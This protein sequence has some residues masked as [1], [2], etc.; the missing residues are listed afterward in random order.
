MQDLIQIYLPLTALLVILVN[1]IFFQ[2]SFLNWLPLVLVLAALG[3]VY[4]N[5]VTLDDGEVPSIVAN[6]PILI[7]TIGT[8]IALSYRQYLKDRGSR[9]Q[10]IALTILFGIAAGITFAFSGNYHSG[11][12]IFNGP[13]LLLSVFLNVMFVAVVFIKLPFLNKIFQLKP[14]DSRSI[15]YKGVIYMIIALSIYLGVFV[16]GWYGVTLFASIFLPT[17]IVLS[18]DENEDLLQMAV[19]S[20]SSIL[21][22]GYVMMNGFGLEFMVSKSE[23]LWGAFIGGFLLVLG[24]LSTL[25]AQSNKAMVILFTGIV[26]G[27]VYGLGYLYEIKENLGGLITYVG[28]LLGIAFFIF[29]FKHKGYNFSIQNGILALSAVLLFTPGFEVTD[30]DAHKGSNAD[31]IEKNQKKL[32]VTNE[33]GEKV[34]SEMIDITQAVGE[35][36]VFLDNS[37][38]KFK[39]VSHGNTTSG[40]F[41]KFTGKVKIAEKLEDCSVEM[42]F[43]AESFSTYNKTRDKEL[44]GGADWM[45]VAKFPEVS[46]EAKGFRVEGNTYVTEGELKMKGISKKIPVKFVFDGKGENNGKEFI[47]VSGSLGLDMTEFGIPESSEV[48]KGVEIEFTIEANKME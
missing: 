13:K 41:K 37:K 2:K 45:D 6:A 28:L 26:L 9:M 25:I 12:T 3:K 1:G 34:E 32:E 14:E 11:D 33:K 18:N 31:K 8:F 17:M 23:F 36:E 42:N 29:G 48:D 19:I 7:L 44:K 39:V 40:T 5:A 16:T 27:M 35:Y 4:G 21:G 47:I 30:P 24:S 43:D 10:L 20:I 22:I 46:F 38:L 15:L